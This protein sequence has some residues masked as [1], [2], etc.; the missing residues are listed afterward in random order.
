MTGFKDR[1]TGF[2]VRS[3]YWHV[4]QRTYLLVICGQMT[5]SLKHPPPNSF[6]PRPQ[7]TYMQVGFVKHLVACPEIASKDGPRGNM[8]VRL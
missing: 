8:P 7:R 1:M 4:S 3:S 5:Q 6:I 2:R